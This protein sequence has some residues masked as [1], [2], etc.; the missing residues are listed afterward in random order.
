[1]VK[2]TAI[3]L[4][5]DNQL[6]KKISV[7]ILENLNCIVDAVMTGEQALNFAD[8]KSYDIILMDIGLPDMDGLTV[9]THIRKNSV[10]NQT[11]P[12]VA[13]TAHLD[14]IYIQQSFA[15]GANDFLVKPMN[16]DVGK[17]ILERFASP[18]IESQGNA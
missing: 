13:L 5:E 14:K 11:T 12:I 8:Q 9:I 1:M 16:Y 3:L 4:V 6:V 10:L 17:N 18:V 2:K 7:L 15:V